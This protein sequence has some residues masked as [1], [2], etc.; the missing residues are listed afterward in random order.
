VFDNVDKVPR[1]IG[2]GAGRQPLADKISSGSAA[3][4]SLRY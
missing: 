4:E 3:L 1:W 2:R